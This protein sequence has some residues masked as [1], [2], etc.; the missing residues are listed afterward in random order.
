MKYVPVEAVKSIRNAAGHR[1]F[2]WNDLIYKKEY[3]I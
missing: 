3:K 1:L 2:V